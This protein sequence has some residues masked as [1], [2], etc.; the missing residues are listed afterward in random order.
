M[1]EKLRE[2]LSE[3]SRGRLSRR[4]EFSGWAFIRRLAC[5][6]TAPSFQTN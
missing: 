6:A 1:T 2:P 3:N 5:L 4:D